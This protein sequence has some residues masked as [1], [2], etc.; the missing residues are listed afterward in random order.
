MFVGCGL[1]WFVV[2]CCLSLVLFAD[3]CELLC[4]VRCALFIARCWLFVVCCLSF[5]V[6][7]VL[8]DVRC[9]FLLFVGR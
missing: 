7:C 5:A 2:W 4:V 8:F 9:L 6:C 1:S 3:C